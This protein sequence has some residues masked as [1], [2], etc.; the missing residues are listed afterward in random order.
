M[1]IE[2][3]FSLA[4]SSVSQHLHIGMWMTFYITAITQFMPSFPYIFKLFVFCIYIIFFFFYSYLSPTKPLVLVVSIST[5]DTISRNVMFIPRPIYSWIVQLTIAGRYAEYYRSKYFYCIL[6]VFCSFGTVTNFV[7]FCVFFLILLLRSTNEESLVHI[8]G[9]RYKVFR[10]LCQDGLKLLFSYFI[11]MK[12]FSHKNKFYFPLN[13]K[14]F[15]T[16]ILILLVFSLQ[17]N[18]FQIN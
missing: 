9:I 15:K 4:I 12:L 1:L 2:E 14:L 6:K 18:D 17:V 13:W 11:Q 5:T 10:T 3:N 7:F 8:H 16:E